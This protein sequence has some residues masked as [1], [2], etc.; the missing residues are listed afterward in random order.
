M[1]SEGEKV[2]H[3]RIIFF[4]Q[5]KPEHLQKWRQ[6]TKQESAKYFI[7]GEQSS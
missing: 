5:A 1:N 7:P 2:R 3:V 4:S 6:L